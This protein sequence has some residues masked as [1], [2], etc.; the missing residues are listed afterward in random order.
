MSDEEVHLDWSAAEV[1][2]GE[3]T[4]PLT[5]ERPKK[6]K[7]AF[8][9]AERLLAISHTDWG[10]ITLEKDTVRVGEVR[11]GAEDTLRFHLEGVVQQAVADVTAPAE[12]DHDDSGQ[13]EGPDAEMTA[14]FRAFSDSKAESESTG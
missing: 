2:D 11:A 6:F 4:V 3:L 5:G 14:R 1:H 7:P 13:P 9:H 10:E 8:E 12:D